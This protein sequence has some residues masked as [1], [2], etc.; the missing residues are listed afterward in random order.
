MK[1]INAVKAVVVVLLVFILSGCDQIM[2]APRNELI[3]DDELLPTVAGI[4]DGQKHVIAEYVGEDFGEKAL[5]TLMGDG[6][7]RCA[8]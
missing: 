6:R 7:K 5:G 8:G 1:V 3:G 4:I 2:A